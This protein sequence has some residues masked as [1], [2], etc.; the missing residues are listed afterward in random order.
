M[1]EPTEDQL[2]H[3]GDAAI[4]PP[5]DHA[6][7]GD[8]VD[9]GGRRWVEIRDHDR[10]A[11]FFVTVVSSSDLWL[12]ASSTGGLTAG[13]VDADR[14]LFPYE[15]EDKVA[16]GADRSGSMTVVRVQRSGGPRHLW[17]PLSDRAPRVYRVARRIRKTVDGDALSFEEA[18][19]DLGI[20][21]IETWALSDRFGIVRD[22][23]LRND[24]CGPDA[25]AHVE[26]VDGF[27]NV[28][29]AGV[30]QQLQ[31]RMSVLLDAYKRSEVDP[32][33]GLGLFT[34]SSTLT[35]R[36]EPSEALRATVCWQLGLPV[37]A[38]W[39]TADDRVEAFRRGARIDGKQDADVRGRPGAFL[40]VSE[41]VLEPE[42]ERRWLTVADVHRDARDI[43][44]LRLL[45]RDRT[46]SDG[47]SAVTEDLERGRHVLRGFVAAA[48]GLSVS[49]D[50]VVTV[51]HFANALFNVMRGGVFRDGSVVETEDFRR[52]VEARNTVVHEAL[53]RELAA[54][55]ER[56]DIRE[57]R[58]WAEGVGQADVIRLV[59]EYLPLTFSRRHGD[60]SRPWNRFS[61]RLRNP[62]GTPR[63]DYEGNWRDIFQN[64]EPLAYAFPGFAMSMVAKFLNATTVDGYNPYRVTRSGIEWEVPEPEDP[65]SNIGY[66]G[67]HQIIY[68]QKLLEAVEALDPGALE[69]H[70]REAI[71]SYANV[72]YRLADYGATVRD[73]ES[74]IRFDD[75][76]NDAIA[77]HVAR[78]GTDARLVLRSPAAAR[79]DGTLPVRHGTLVEKL[80]VLLLVKVTNLVPGSGIWMNTQR[81]EWNDANNALVGKGVSV[82]TAAYLHRFVADWRRRSRES[83]GDRGVGFRVWAPVARLARRVRETLEARRGDLDPEGFPASKRRALMDELGALATAYRAEVYEP[84][85]DLDDLELSGDELRGLLDVV[86]EYLVQSLR[87]RRRPDGLGHSYDIVAFAPGQATI[88]P[89]QV[90][91]EGQVALLSSGILSPRESLQVLDALRQSALYWPEQRTYLLYPNERLPGF[92]EKNRFPAHRMADSGLARALIDAG[93]TR[94]ILVDPFDG[95]GHFGG[96]LRNAAD[97]ETLLDELAE[98]P[99]YAALVERE[100][101]SFLT[102][103][104]ETFDH[105]SFTGRSGTFFAYEGLGSVYWHMV[106]KLLLAVQETFFRAL[107]DEGAGDRE[108]VAE[109][110][111]AYDDV[112]AGLGFNKTP[113]QYGAFP[114]DPYSHTPET[115]NARQPGMTG[116]VKEELL[117][118]M[119]E[120]G[121]RVGAGTMAFRPALLHARELFDHAVDFPYVDVW[122]HRRTV[123]FPAGG[124]AFTFAQTPIVYETRDV[125]APSGRVVF[126]DGSE[127]AFPGRTLPREIAQHVF[128]RDGR[129]RAIHVAVDPADLRP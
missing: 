79:R 89:L 8:L 76:E 47:M 101:A 124:I 59:F 62:D 52:F 108:A 10:M 2:L 90:M 38:R 18:N 97:L 49:R 123:P 73:P 64:W 119:G 122:G 26:M 121:V 78:C 6:P 85:G 60:P 9:H 88:R 12:F 92:L 114:T 103:F 113:A 11:P 51:H 91:L 84:A 56:L 30:T 41:L 40:T 20:T 39:L 106:S 15:T 117:T 27:R 104:E 19:L 120:L 3:L 95:A 54:L 65:W 86:Q 110:A 127:V 23:R 63:T 100:R 94:L 29:P 128:S 22:A 75:E 111:G 72:P 24:G 102:L 82:V 21:F 93:D 80:L 98:D 115:G 96:D 58:D 37:A 14:A 55:P 105:A 1:N 25:G 16:H 33:T 32:A 44:E 45:L 46:E 77:Q 83:E 57:L 13:R 35:D 4:V 34:L 118:R 81:P 7:T 99:R 53:R 42:A 71:F 107:E 66:W 67:D 48:D 74:T 87:A 43:G 50:E 28:L 112:R 129:V 109:L 116:Q 5:G 17:E 36:A 68:L 125:A 61:I 70:G 126:E 69:R 31:T